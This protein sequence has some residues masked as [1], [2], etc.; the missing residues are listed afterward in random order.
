MHQSYLQGGASVKELLTAS[1]YK[2]IVNP[3]GRLSGSLFCSRVF[4]ILGE[5]GITRLFLSDQGSNEGLNH[6]VM[7]PGIQMNPI[8]AEK[9]LLSAESPPDI[10]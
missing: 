2:S 10:N 8:L 4:L 5:K 7:A 6:Q 1:L 9:V 3:S